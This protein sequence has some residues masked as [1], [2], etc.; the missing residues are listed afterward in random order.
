MKALKLHLKKA[1]DLVG[2][3]VNKKAVRRYA[4]IFMGLFLVICAIVIF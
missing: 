3:L 1:D 4:S 2:N